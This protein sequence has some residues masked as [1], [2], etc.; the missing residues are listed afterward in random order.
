METQLPHQSSNTWAR[1]QTL[2]IAMKTRPELVDLA[3]ASAKE[4]APGAVLLRGGFPYL[5]KVCE[6]VVAAAALGEQA[7]GARSPD[8]SSLCG[9]FLSGERFS[10]SSTQSAASILEMSRKV[11]P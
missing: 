6:G 3:K 4:K 9:F 1:Q 10:V 11:I 2:A 7:G 5:P 8:A